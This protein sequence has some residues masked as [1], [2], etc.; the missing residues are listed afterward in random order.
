MIQKN[1][2]C[3]SFELEMNKLTILRDKDEIAEAGYQYPLDGDGD[4]V[5]RDDYYTV[6]DEEDEKH[7]LQSLFATVRNHWFLIVAFTLSITAGTLVY[8]A[9]QPNYFRAT[10]RVQV[11][12]EINPG[13][14]AKEGGSVILN[15]PGSD[16]AYFATQLQI[17][18]G[19]GLMRRVITT[20]DLENNQAFLNPQGNQKLSIWQNIQKMLGFDRPPEVAEENKQL[21]P[22]VPKNNLGLKNGPPP[23]SEQQAEKLAPYVNRLQSDLSIS[24][25][26]DNR[27]SAQETRLIDINFIHLD[28]VVAAKIAN[29]IG[30]AY[31]LE[32]LE[33]KVQTNA[34]AGDF[35]QKRVAELQSEIRN[36]EERLMNYAR[37]NRIISLD[38]SQNTVVQRLTALN[39]SLGQAEN[40]RIAAQAAYQA[41]KQNQ[42][43]NSTA[44]SKDPKVNVLEAQLT[45]LEQKLAQLRNEYTD[46]WYEVVQTR[47]QI[48]NVENQLKVIRKKAI[49]I[50]FSAIEEKLNETTAREKV[51]REN[52][53]VQR[54]EVIRQNEASINYKI[55][56]QEI[57]TNK[58]LLDGLLQRSKSN[59]I[60]ISGTQN[61]VLVLDRALTPE[62][63]AGP[64]RNRSL[65]I[66]IIASLF[67]GFGFA[68]L[69]DWLNDTI[70]YS[71]DIENQLALPLLAA[72]PALPASIG[73]KLLPSGFALT[74]KRRRIQ[75]KYD[76][77]AFE[78]PEFQESYMQLAAYVKLSTAGGPPRIILVTSSEEGEG[79]TMT[80]INLAA[81][82]ASA[83][84]KVLIIDADLRCPRIHIVK[85]VNNLKGLTTLLTVD[86]ATPELIT[87]AIQ[88]DS[89]SNL[90]I[91]TAGALTANPGNLLSSP[92]MAALLEHLSTIYTHI[93][94]DSPPVLFYADSAIISTMSDAVLMVVRDSIS[95]RSSVIN[96]KK[97]LQKVGAKLVG[98]VLNGVPI[99]KTNYYSYYYHDVDKMLAAENGNDNGTDKDNGILDLE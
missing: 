21:P 93:I 7:L 66:A 17:L 60:V 72:I 57:D 18:E 92:E 95:T 69:I 78:K 58:S 79:K 13:L 84:G 71:H 44:E 46:D 3:T 27:T 25:V 26:M 16:P 74:R 42:M 81:S 65:F 6:A 77:E 20:L 14:A 99:G 9:Q 98:V 4:G 50:Q 8:V 10:A 49:G 15:N 83:E 45:T 75:R 22:A 61:N 68:Y 28:P 47:K 94:I 19:S 48:E 87:D 82:L 23:N 12:S 90:D 37:S 97:T 64:D 85:N 86:K 33:K 32:N 24:P 36:S 40:E 35:L 55:I 59:E 67:L 53:N 34:S 80:S 43:W 2:T 38:E 91:L 54:E 11:N 62:S 39:S 56:Q 76:Q 29:A 41:A 5:F 89:H 1:L 73:S 51:L 96:A 63:P 88:T 70:N 31:V 52:F 30:D